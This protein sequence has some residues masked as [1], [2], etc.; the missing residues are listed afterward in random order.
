MATNKIILDDREQYY[1]PYT[2]DCKN[3]VHFD[4]LSLSCKAFF[5]GIPITI[6]S[7]DKKH[8]EPWKSQKNKIVFKAK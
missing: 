4:R 8:R 2:S 3:C 5:K 1:S 7:G 6:L